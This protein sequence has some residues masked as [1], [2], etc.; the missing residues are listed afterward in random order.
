MSSCLCSP[1]AVPADI[2]CNASNVFNTGVRNPNSGVR[3]ADVLLAKPSPS[4]TPS[5]LLSILSQSQGAS[6]SQI[7][8]LLVTWLLHVFEL[9]FSAELPLLPA[10]ESWFP[11]H[12]IVPASYA[13]LKMAHEKR[14]REQSLSSC[15]LDLVT[16]G[17]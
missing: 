17:I 1:I 12:C 14:F 9:H 10:A 8:I 5:P 13:Y 3:T 15:S 16:K 4:T 11:L 7:F 6:F 2:C